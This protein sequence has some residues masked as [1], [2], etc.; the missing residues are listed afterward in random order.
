LS[1]N[2]LKIEY[3]LVLEEKAQR[4]ARSNLLDF[5]E[6]TF[7]D[8]Q[9]NW[10][11]EILC[12]ALEEFV[13]G[14]IE[15][16]I[17]MMPPRH[18]K[19]ELVSRRLPAYIFGKNPDA[20]IIACS[21]AADLA[22]RM[23]RDVQRIMES[24]N[25]TH[26][27]PD[28]RLFSSNVRSLAKNTW[29]KNTDIF[30]IVD[31]RG[32]YRASGIGGGI[33]GHG[34]DVG[35]IDDP[36]KNQKEAG[37]KV[38]RDAIWEWYTTTFMTRMEKGAQKLVTMTRWHDDDLCGRLLAEMKSDPNAD[39]WE[40]IR[41]QGIKTSKVFKI[42]IDNFKSKIKDPRKDGD[43]L[44]PAKQPLK[45]LKTIKSAL[46]RLFSGLF[47]QD[48]A[49]QEG[50][51]L[52]RI[53]LQYYTEMPRRFDE[54]VQSWDATFKDTASSNFVAGHVWGRIGAD[55][56]LVDRV[57]EKMDFTDTLKAINHLTTKHP[58]ARRKLIEDKANGPAI[59]SVLK[60]K[61][62][63]LIAINPHGNK[64]ERVQAISPMWESMNV[65]LPHTSI[66]PWITEVVEE[67]MNFP[68]APNDDDVDAMSQVLNYF[69]E[70]TLTTYEK[71]L[72][73]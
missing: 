45:K 9:A 11:H 14:K 32:V 55:A 51:I 29:L 19:S 64:E 26:L 50:N 3:A 48:P 39:Q 60:S 65:W 10:H 46:K 53:H 28:S 5:T 8:Y 49:L 13:A 41:F 69:Y 18:G 62:S 47:Q 38:F 35:I 54:L 16:M 1:V 36:I 70:R 68:N 61:I 23:N 30:E 66:A 17:V 25:Y 15:N 56:Y 71:L 7:Y 33:T 20:Q 67:F 22:R 34:F 2:A 27:F 12:E 44:W 42:G 24:D 21:Y 59:I 52:K 4:L 43:A 72:N 63:G 58:N 6:Y 37:S 31:H 73:F 57:H 40:V